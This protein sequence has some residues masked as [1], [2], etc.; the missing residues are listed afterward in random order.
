MMSGTKLTGT[1]LLGQAWPRHFNRPIAEDMYSNIRMVGLPTWTDADQTFAKA[2][3]K[4]MGSEEPRGLAGE[5]QRKGEKDEAGDIRQ[6]LFRLC[7]GGHAA[8]EGAAAGEQGQVGRHPG[9]LGR[10]RAHHRMRQPRRI[11]PLRP[12]FHVEELVAQRRDSARDP[13]KTRGD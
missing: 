1:R 11:G 4:E 7:A 2:V 5:V 12:L 13:A 8:A 10:R 3:Q 9:R 6:R